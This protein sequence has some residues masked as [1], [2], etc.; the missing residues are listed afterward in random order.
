LESL[1]GISV[2]LFGALIALF[3]SHLA[4]NATR[5][6]KQA[7]KSHRKE[8]QSKFVQVREQLN[9]LLSDVLDDLPEE[10]R[11][12]YLQSLLYS[13]RQDGSFP[14]QSL[15]FSGSLSRDDIDREVEKRTKALEERILDIENRFPSSS[16]IE[17]VASV[18]DAIL[19][20]NLES[21]AESVKR[22]EDKMLSKWDVAKVVFQIIA[23]LGGLIAIA[24]T[25]IGFVIG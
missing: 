18:N 10:S 25:I 21:L 5:Q 16:T 8:A 13:Q 11:E 6:R 20:T 3:L 19:A 17:K 9:I 12:K 7:L 14:D 4:S 24:L 1:I 15:M 22:L 23:V 2:S